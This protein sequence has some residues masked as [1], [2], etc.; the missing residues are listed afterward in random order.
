M[1]SDTS[2][3][4]RRRTGPEFQAG[5]TVP[6]LVCSPLFQRLLTLRSAGRISPS[7]WSLLPGASALTRTG[8]PPVRTTRLSGR[9]MRCSISDIMWR[10]D[11]DLT[12]AAS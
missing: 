3:P 6:P 1:P 4:D 9:T 2:P 7:G 12:C 10:C 8:L 5:Y 11:G